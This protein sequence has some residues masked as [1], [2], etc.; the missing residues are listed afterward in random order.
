MAGINRLGKAPPKPGTLRPPDPNK[1]RTVDMFS[2]GAEADMDYIRTV[3]DI[4]EMQ[5][6]QGWLFGRGAFDKADLL[7]LRDTMEQQRH[8]ELEL[9]DNERNQ[10]AAM[11]ARLEKEQDEQRPAAALR[12]PKRERENDVKPVIKALPKVRPIVMPKGKASRQAVA[13]PGEKKAK[14]AAEHNQ[15]VSTTGQGPGEPSTSQGADSDED[16]GGLAG[17]LGGYGSD[18]DSEA[19]EEGSK[20]PTE[21]HGNHSSN[22]QV[23]LPSAEELL[24][25]SKPVD[26]TLPP[27]PPPDPQGKAVW[28]LDDEEPEV[29]YEDEDEY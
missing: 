29:D 23:A 20:A 17:L 3:R 25:S 12:P 15:P 11:R 5:Q 18:S 1:Y 21:Q 13:Q 19:P 28:V 26:S 6:Q 22:P 24:D 9:R 10:F 7:Y 8:M 27:R 4:E 14:T 2:E 16:G